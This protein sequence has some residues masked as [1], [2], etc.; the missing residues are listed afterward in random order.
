MQEL[1]QRYIDYNSMRSVLFWDVRTI[2]IPG[3][4]LNAYY[5]GGTD[6]G[7]GCFELI[8]SGNITISLYNYPCILQQKTLSYIYQKY[9][10]QEHYLR[11]LM[12]KIDML[13]FNQITLFIIILTKHMKKLKQLILP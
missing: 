11:N 13:L 6:H 5:S 4:Y 9:L 2:I 3:N 7:K 1:Y 8:S 12:I 10:K